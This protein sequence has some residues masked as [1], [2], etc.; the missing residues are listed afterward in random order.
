MDE[1]FDLGRDMTS[2]VDEAMETGN[3]A[4]RDDVLREGLRLV[5]QRE[6]K[7]AEFFALIDEG[8]ADCEAGRVIDAEEVFRE[9]D[10]EFAELE[11]RGG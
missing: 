9:L 7:R 3:Y 11:R 10:E 2:I 8:I 5:Q 6:R 1:R 4:T